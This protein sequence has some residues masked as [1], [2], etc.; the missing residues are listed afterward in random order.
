MSHLRRSH[1]LRN[2]QEVDGAAF[3]PKVS[4]WSLLEEVRNSVSSKVKI[5]GGHREDKEYTIPCQPQ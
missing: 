1:I 4:S 3:E 5:S 2:K